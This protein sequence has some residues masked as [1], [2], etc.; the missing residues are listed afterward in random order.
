MRGGESGFVYL[1]LI[2]NARSQPKSVC[3]P[4]G[5]YGSKTA[6]QS[7]RNPDGVHGI[8]YTGDIYHPHF[9]SAYSAYNAQAS[10][11]PS[12]VLDDV[13]VARLSTTGAT[14]SIHPDT[15]F[16]HLGCSY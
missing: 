11:P 1:G 6:E 14:G 7:V 2:T 8:A 12:I 13:V 3:N 5:T 15:L 16:F 9:N 4:T 10:N